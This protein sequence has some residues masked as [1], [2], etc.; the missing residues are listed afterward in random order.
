[1]DATSKP[2]EQPQQLAKDDNLVM[3]YQS[4]VVGKFKHVFKYPKYFPNG[5]LEGYCPLEL[6]QDLV[7]E[8]CEEGHSLNHIRG[9]EGPQQGKECFTLSTWDR[10]SMTFVETKYFQ[11][12]RPSTET[13]YNK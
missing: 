1:M 13:Q 2:D 3:E 8:L 9:G 5:Y 12:L 10:V 7:D 4:A 11:V 6:V